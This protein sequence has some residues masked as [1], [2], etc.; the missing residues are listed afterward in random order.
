MGIGAGVVLLVLGS[1]VA[2]TTLVLTVSVKRRDVACATTTFD[3][4]AASDAYDLMRMDSD[5]G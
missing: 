4:G 2:A 1:L 3:A 5:K